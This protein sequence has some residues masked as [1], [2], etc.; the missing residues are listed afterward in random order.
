MPDK[1]KLLY[2]WCGEFGWEVMTVVPEINTL[3]HGYDVTLYG[4]KGTE[5]MYS[6]MKI[7]YVPHQLTLRGAGY[8]CTQGS[9]QWQMLDIGQFQ[10]DFLR[11][12]YHPDSSK[13]SV[14][15]KPKI[16][17]TDICPSK[18]KKVTVHARRF[19]VSKTGRNWH[20]KFNETLEYLKGLGFEIVFI[21]I[22]NCSFFI[23]G[24]GEDAR[25]EDM[26]TT[27]KHIKESSFVLGP[28]SGPM[29]LSL[30]C[31]TPVFTWSCGDTRMFHT[32]RGSKD[33]NPFLVKHY[34]PWSANETEAAIKLYRSSSYKP[35]TEEM[36]T[37]LDFM[38][39]TE[40]LI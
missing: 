12:H 1:P 17:R 25:S 26:G 29:V 10:Y 15:K 9:T 19:Q 24:F 13:M 27:V 18:K 33:W 4:Y 40:G 14:I 8:G 21:G 11:I 30:W 31:G 34:H 37:G 6:D 32:S 7:K 38:L 35:T 22:P 28:S 39:K 2:A 16:I 5:G 23:E 3:Q 20:T 36:R